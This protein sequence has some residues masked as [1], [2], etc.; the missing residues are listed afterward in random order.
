[1]W[2][3][4][5]FGWTECVFGALFNSLETGKLVVVCVWLHF[6][7]CVEK[8]L[9]CIKYL[10]LYSLLTFLMLDL[11][12]LLF[13]CFFSFL[14]LEGLLKKYFTHL[15]SYEVCPGCPSFGFVYTQFT[16]RKNP[17]WPLEQTCLYSSPISIYFNRTLCK[18]HVTII[19]NKINHSLLSFQT[20]T[21][22][23]YIHTL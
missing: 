23:P 9:G 19:L 10:T 20:I 16:K 15:M 8:Y 21:V 7:S 11:I 2:W 5:Q 14:S 3:G 6:I 17:W 22:H 1:M 13:P 4:S 12:S 18:L